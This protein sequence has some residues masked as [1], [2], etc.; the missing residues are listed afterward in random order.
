M[1]RRALPAALLVP[2]LATPALGYPDRPLRLVVAYPAGGG[3]DV[4]ARAI[5]GHMQRSLGQA[6]VVENRTGASGT[7][8]AQA[9]AAAP[10]D[11]HTLLFVSTSEMALRPLLDRQLPYSIDRDFVPVALLGSTPV[12]LA[13]TAALP[14]RDVAELV[15]LAKARPGSLSYASTG[16]GTLMHLTG[17]LFRHRAGIDILHVP[18]R[19][20]APAVNDTVA[21]QVQLIF[22]GLTPVLPMA[23]AGR[24]RLL[25]VSTAARTAAAPE[26]PTLEELGLGD[27]DMAN[28]V[29]I[30]APRGTP[31]AVVQ[32]LNTAANAAAADP[33]VRNI[34]IANGADT[35][36]ST[37]AEFLNYGRAQRARF[38]EVIR[39]TGIRLE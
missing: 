11:G 30:V 2:L 27:F 34:F 17:E 39:V 4:M 18:Y 3:T 8:G 38:A 20:G 15:A 5:A 14:A 36:G 13:V 16:I 1:R 25:A 12:V 37:P 23:Q 6:I 21:G 33:G 9:V 19:G 31:P 24:L 28:A 32:A 29:G 35:L 10:A 26:V 7:I 22:N